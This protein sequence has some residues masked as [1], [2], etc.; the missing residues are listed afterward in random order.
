MSYLNTKPLIYGLSRHPV[1]AE[2]ELIVD[3]PAHI[4]RM[5][6]EGQIDVGLVP[7]AI[8]PELEESHIIT[9]YCIG[10]NGAV[11]S[12]AIFSEQPMESISTIILDYQSRTSVL[13][14]RVLMQEYWKKEVDWKDAKGEEYRQQIKDDVA[15]VVIGDRALEQ[16]KIST[17]M[18]DLGLAWKNHTGLP[19]VFAAWIS[20]KTLPAS[21]I[22]A[23]NEANRMG[24]DNLEE[25]VA[26]EDHDHVALRKYYT[27]NI[28][29]QLNAEK[30]KGLAHF[31]SK[32]K[33][34]KSNKTAL[35]SELPAKK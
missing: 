27:E 13:L 16:K 31:L 30:K 23:F 2:I 33:L 34:L 22:K 9:D 4:A 12:V 32:I 29:Y 24:L 8:I 1:E 20:N 26:L 6:I 10:C 21:F 14:S 15:G 19:F 17:Y 7:V 18:Y 28:S 11:D 3:Y 5:L 25:V 35:S